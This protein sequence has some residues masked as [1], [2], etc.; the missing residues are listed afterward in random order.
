MIQLTYIIGFLLIALGLGGYLIADERPPTALIPAAFGL[1]YVV[2]AFVGKNERTRKHVMHGASVL[3]LLGML[4]TG[5]G[6]IALLQLPFGLEVDRPLAV[7]SQGC[8]FVLSAIFLVAAV[9]SF[10]AARRARQA[11]EGEA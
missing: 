1:I 8:T 4:G 9:R 2:L 3:A 6:F 7:I 5:T 11:S 10:I